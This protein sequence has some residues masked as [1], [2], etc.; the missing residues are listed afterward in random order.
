[1]TDRES[2]N[3][4]ATWLQD[5][6]ALAN[7]DIAVVLVGSKLDR[8]DQREVSFMEAAR[9]AQENGVHF[10]ES[11]ALSGENVE[12]VFAKCARGILSR[13][14]TGDIDPDV[15]GFGVEKAEPAP[16]TLESRCCSS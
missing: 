12:E 9:F 3:H 8:D 15:Q 6:R 10:F 1:M 7:P 5:A 2:Y 13:I 11:S 16:S 4:V 14:D